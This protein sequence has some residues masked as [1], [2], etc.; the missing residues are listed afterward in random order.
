MATTI[1]LLI[2]LAVYTITVVGINQYSDGEGAPWNFDIERAFNYVSKHQAL[3]E[4]MPIEPLQ[5]VIGAIALI[6]PSL[7]LFWV[8]RFIVK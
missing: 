5:M 6:L 1:A 2:A 7:L 8:V 4:V 3:V